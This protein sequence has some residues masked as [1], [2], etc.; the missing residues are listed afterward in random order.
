V[1]YDIRDVPLASMLGS[2]GAMIEPQAR[3]KRLRYTC[4]P[5]DPTVTACADA[6]KLEQILLNLLSNAVK[7]TPAGGE[8]ALSV[9]A[10][11]EEVRISVRDTGRGIPADR[12]HAVFEPFVQLDAALTRQHEGTGLGLA[13]SQD[14]ARGMGGEISVDSAIGQGSTFTLVLPAGR[15]VSRAMPRPVSMGELLASEAQHIVRRVVSRL[16]ADP[17]VP[18]ASQ[19][20]LEDHLASLVTDV[21]QLLVILDGAPMRESA[22]LIADGSRIQR[23]IT[24][25]HGA[26]R[27]RLGWTARIIEREFDYLGEEVAAAL[28]RRAPDDP[29]VP[30]E[31]TISLVR[32]LL[33]EARSIAARSV[34]A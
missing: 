28:R 21:A 30:L 2:L 20:E 32:A 1:G 33:E 15:P 9:E 3:E 8:V 24:K 10:D 25:L 29:G 11:D 31:E 18:D 13:I 27:R 34:A 7:F 5:G 22:P 16:R 4:E 14:L 26:Q 23:M 6:P 19:P 12:L 17:E